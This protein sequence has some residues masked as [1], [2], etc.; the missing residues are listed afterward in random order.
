MHRHPRIA[1]YSRTNSYY[2]I[3]RSWRGYHADLLRF[4]FH[5]PVKQEVCFSKEVFES[6]SPVSIFL[7]NC[8]HTLKLYNGD[9]YVANLTGVARNI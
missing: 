4:R 1:G 2:T 7:L 3:Q 8:S 6:D 9:D 5:E